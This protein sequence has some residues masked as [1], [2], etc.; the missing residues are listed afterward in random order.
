MFPEKWY[1]HFIKLPPNILVKNLSKNINETTQEAPQSQ[2]TAP[3]PYTHT[4]PTTPS[5]PPPPLPPHHQTHTRARARGTRVE[6]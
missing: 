1:Q 2:S 6:E 3:P 5:S 4:H